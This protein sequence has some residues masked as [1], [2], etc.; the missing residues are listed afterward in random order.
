MREDADAQSTTSTSTVCVCVCLFICVTDS[1]IYRARVHGFGTSTAP[2]A[3]P[4]GTNKTGSTAT[5]C[6]RARAHALELC[7]GFYD[8]TKAQTSRLTPTS[9]PQKLLPNLSTITKYGR[10][11]CGDR[12]LAM[13]PGHG[14]PWGCCLVTWNPGRVLVGRLDADYAAARLTS[15]RVLRD[16]LRLGHHISI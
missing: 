3:W 15:A 1:D 11:A 4:E 9:L 14:A 8:T 5:R 12:H 6:K 10:T 13:Q 16:R 7:K 2:Q